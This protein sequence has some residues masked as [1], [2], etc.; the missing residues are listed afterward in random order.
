MAARHTRPAKYTDLERL[1]GNLIGE[2]IDGDLYAWPRPGPAHAR[3]S[4]ALGM[5]IGS[6]YD[7]G[8]GGPGG[9]WIF[10]EP[11]LQFDHQVLVPGLAGWRR[12]RMPVLPKTHVFDVSPDWI[13]E[14]LSPGT[15]RID[16]G[17][18]MRIYGEQQVSYLW[19]LDPLQ[20]TMETY[21]L[22]ERRWVILRNYTGND[23][24]RAEP[25][26]LAEVDLASIWGET[27]ADFSP[28][29]AP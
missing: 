5:D 16:R 28:L 12:E 21:Q 11:E 29:P 18:K 4:S 8:R 10:D 2:I 1:P 3:C 9:W 25:F 27:P 7:R 15:A 19:L 6:P 14:I 24:V 23:V 26:P 20:Q 22:V 17:K 13:C